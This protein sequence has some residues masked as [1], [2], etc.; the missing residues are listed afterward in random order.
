[1]GVYLREMGIDA[2]LF[3]TI[4][5][6][7]FEMPKLLQRDDIVRFGLDRTEFGETAWQLVDKVTPQIR[8][9]F[10]VR[11]DGEEA[12]FVNGVLQITCVS[13][14][15]MTVAFGPR[16]FETQMRTSHVPSH[17]IISI[18]IGGKKVSLRRSASPKFYVR[19]GG[20][21]SLDGAMETTTEP[22]AAES[23]ERNSAM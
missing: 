14:L 12:H 8:K 20:T 22:P 13:G 2:A 10:F 21:P 18:A 23:G 11:T 1:M 9:R 5:A 7:P 17:P 19:V 15:G 4:L 16:A 3:S 6:T